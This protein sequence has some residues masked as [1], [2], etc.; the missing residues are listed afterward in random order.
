MENIKSKGQNELALGH[1]KPVSSLTQIYYTKSSITDAHKY[2]DSYTS[3]WSRNLSK[4]MSK[5]VNQRLIESR[6]QSIGTINYLF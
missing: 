3:L 4:F 2:T 6:Q 5:A 1:Q